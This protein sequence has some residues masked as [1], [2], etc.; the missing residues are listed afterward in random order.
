MYSGIQWFTL[1]TPKPPNA[2]K[3]MK[4]SSLR[5][6][7]VFFLSRGFDPDSPVLELPHSGS[8]HPHSV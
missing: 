8:E 4:T 3:K 2:V 1:I 7:K 6:V 5:A